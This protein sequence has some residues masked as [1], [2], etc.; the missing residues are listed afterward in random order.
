MDN[1]KNSF[2]IFISYKRK[3]LPTA[4]NLYYRLTT[5]GYT[6]FFDLEEMGR[7][8][9]NTQL[10]TYIERANDVFVI[11]EEGS[12]AA[13]LTDE[14]EKDW[15]C[16]EV[17]YALEKKK[18][19][20]PILLGGFQMPPE[21]FF[22]E[23][24]KE[25]TYKNAPIF[26]FSYF[27]AYLDK[28][29]EKN[30]LIS[31]PNVQ[32]EDSSVFK[33]YSDADCQVFKE[34]KL[35]CSLKGMSDE[36]YYLLVNRKGDYRFKVIN[37]ETSQSKV[38]REHIDIDEEKE[39]DVTWTDSATVVRQPSPQSSP[40]P[41]PQAQVQTNVS[42]DK[43]F[44]NAYQDWQDGEYGKAFPLFA[45]L[46]EKGYKKAYGYVGLC[47]ELGQGVQTD[48]TKAEYFYNLAIDAKDYL[49]VY[50]LGM[51]YSKNAEYYKAIW[52]YEKTISEGWAGGDA[53]LNM[54]RFYENGT[55][56]KSNLSKAIEFYRMAK[57][58]HSSEASDALLRLGA[59]Y[60]EEAFDQE[61]PASV[62]KMS[63]E[64][65]YSI[66]EQ[67]GRYHNENIPLAYTYY[68]VAAS[69]N[70]P[71]AAYR[72]VQL[73]D[74]YDIPM[75]GDDLESYLDFASENMLPFVKKN[76]SYAWDAGYV[77]EYGP[78]S[79]RDKDKAYQCYRIG[80]ENGDV[81]CHWALGKMLESSKEFTKAFMHYKIAAE[82]G[83]GMAMFKLADFYE[84]G[85]G[86]KQDINS[87]ISWYEKCAKSN[88]ASA[89]DARDRLRKL[90][91]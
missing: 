66:A 15:F 86:I 68:K 70:H 14:W 42:M 28:L 63:A 58:R 54:A 12:L 19:I 30:I 65:L 88:Y 13:C 64:K 77:Y 7:E 21:D 53:Y 18:N 74:E 89:S 83:Q 80:A 84:N 26:D 90:R 67:N 55:G 27:E 57:E 60:D 61:I 87:A 29:I 73:A 38:I 48:P 44:E 23:K 11:L 91:G 82:G 81:S 78:H 20:V 79:V 59:L 39:I 47:Y 72:I 45:A 6:T 43:Q 56:V 32:T 85:L 8:N 35:V 3:S 5:R 71:L 62:M 1:I 40:Q 22:P 52:L 25:L 24:L 36:P 33:F 16:Q 75:T 69:K 46:A 51:I 31:K 2:D 76:P 49:G 10:L 34:G 50:R 41:A 17:A 9:F 4:N 37:E